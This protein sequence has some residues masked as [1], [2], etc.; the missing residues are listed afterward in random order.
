[1]FFSSSCQVKDG[2]EAWPRSIAFVNYQEAYRFEYNARVWI[3]V[4]A[5]VDDAKWTGVSTE[6]ARSEE[7]LLEKRY[8]AGL[9]FETLAESIKVPVVWF[10]I[11]NCPTRRCTQLP[12]LPS[13]SDGDQPGKVMSE[14]MVD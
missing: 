2:P 7:M 9:Y 3:G 1:M 14:T 6:Y 5:C 11:T 8:D 10:K 4:S 12:E 13:N